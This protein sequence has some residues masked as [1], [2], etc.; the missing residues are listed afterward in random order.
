[1]FF[2]CLATIY[3]TGFGICLIGGSLWLIILN[4]WG[5]NLPILR[6]I[7]S[8]IGWPFT[9]AYLGYKLYQIYQEPEWPSDVK[10]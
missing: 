9:F 1:M 7:L 8:I 5:G 2:I 6:T 3:G 10:K 4:K